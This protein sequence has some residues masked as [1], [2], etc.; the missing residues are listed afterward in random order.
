MFGLFIKHK[1]KVV[2]QSTMHPNV[3]LTITI[4]VEQY[5]VHCPRFTFTLKEKTNTPEYKYGYPFLEHPLTG[6]RFNN[7]VK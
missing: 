7:R 4:Q 1:N 6:L 3:T 5:K 2:K